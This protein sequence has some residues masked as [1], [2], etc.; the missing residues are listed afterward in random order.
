MA[1]TSTPNFINKML[2]L[3][4]TRSVDGRIV[5]DNPLLTGSKRKGPR[6]LKL[7]ENTPL[8][9]LWNFFLTEQYDT[10]ETLKN[11]MNRY[12][13]I[14][15]AIKNNSLIQA[16]ADLYAD[17]AT[18]CDVSGDPV[19]VNAKSDVAAAIEDCFEQW[20][21]NQQTVRECIYNKVAFGDSFDTNDI[22]E[23]EGI[24]AVTP[25]SVWD[26]SDRLEFD[27]S[28]LLEHLK[29]YANNDGVSPAAKLQTLMNDLEKSGTNPSSYFRSI[30]LASS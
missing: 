2:G 1:N 20:G 3:F 18:Q 25:L 5:P 17:E 6:G 28:K 9:M 27:P 12:T 26:V 8:S 21:I 22:D 16:A 24:R 13:D 10:Y 23:K 30:C 15:F 7:P 14:D 19:R 11:R 4:N 29:F